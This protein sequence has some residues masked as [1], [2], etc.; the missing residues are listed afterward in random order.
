MTG[1]EV[2][3][4]GVMPDHFDPARIHAGSSSGAHWAVTHQGESSVRI[5]ASGFV[6]ALLLGWDV[7]GLERD[8]DGKWVLKVVSR[9]RVLLLTVGSMVM[10]CLLVMAVLTIAQRKD[11]SQGIHLPP[12]P[13]LLFLAVPLVLMDA[14]TVPWILR[15]VAFQSA[16]SWLERVTGSDGGM[17]PPRR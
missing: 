15:N 10:T 5:Q 3:V 8:V 13:R 16:V 2:S 4:S 14:V 17:D 7:L 1:F 6:S 11:F 9:S 12:L